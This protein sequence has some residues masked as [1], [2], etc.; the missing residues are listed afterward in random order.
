MAPGPKREAAAPPTSRSNSGL[1]GTDSALLRE[2]RGLSERLPALRAR[3]RFVRRTLNLGGA[4]GRESQR[5]TERES[6]GLGQESVVVLCVVCCRQPI[7]WRTAGAH[8]R[9]QEVEQ[10]RLERMKLWAWPLF[11]QNWQCRTARSRWAGPAG[12]REVG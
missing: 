6:R 1:P 8:P 10:K 2:G 3:R 11:P 12:G 7:G 4:G 9:A 5:K